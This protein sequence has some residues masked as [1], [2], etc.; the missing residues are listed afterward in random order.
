MKKIKLLDGSC[1]YVD[2]LCIVVFFGE[3]KLELK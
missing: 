2:M 1:K 3:K